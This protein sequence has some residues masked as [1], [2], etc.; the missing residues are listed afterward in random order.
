MEEKKKLSSTGQKAMVTITAVQLENLLRHDTNALQQVQALRESG[1]VKT[2]G[3][4]KEDI[5]RLI[6]RAEKE[7]TNE[8]ITAVHGPVVN[9]RLA[10]ASA[11]ARGTERS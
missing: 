10:A 6:R 2:C 1:L 5:K 8:K 7:S 11:L 3:L 9:M 4:A